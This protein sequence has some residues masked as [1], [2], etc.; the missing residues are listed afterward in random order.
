[1]IPPNINFHE[2]VETA[3]QDDPLLNS[4]L[5]RNGVKFELTEKI[6]WH[7][8]ERAGNLNFHEIYV[9]ISV[10]DDYDESLILGY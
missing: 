7:Y 9:E 1:M 3:D 2:I 10:Q 5:F 6:T 8:T 4:Q